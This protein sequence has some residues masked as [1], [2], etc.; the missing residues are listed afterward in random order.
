MIPCPAGVGPH[1]VLDLELG[2]AEEDV[3]ALLLEADDGA[4]DDAQ[5][6]RAD[7]AVVLEDDL[8]LVRAEELEGRAEVVEVEQGQV[9]VVAVLEDEREDAGLGLV[10]VE[11]L[12]EEE[13]PE[14]VDGR[15]DLRAE[16]AGE[17]EELDRVAVRLEVPAE[18]L[19]PRLDLRVRRVTGEG[20]AGQVALDVGHEH[21]HAGRGE[22]AGQDLEGLGLAGAGCPGDQPV[23]VDHGE[24]DLDAYVPDRDGP[25]HRRAQDQRRLVER[26]PGR[27]RLVER[28]LHDVGSV[29]R[30]C[31]PASVY[32]VVG[33]PSS[34]C[35]LP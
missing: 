6:R 8:P 22:L 4:K 28:W 20:E 19:R 5:G 13:R 31:R 26:V 32:C 9:V 23:A 18:L 12:A 2:L 33:Q 27:H 35:T 17:R 29:A 1:E 30:P 10:E 25:V 3:G 16:L 34:V 11:D 7:P 15:P 14:R 21:R 24:G